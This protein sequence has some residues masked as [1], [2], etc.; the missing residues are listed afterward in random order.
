MDGLHRKQGNRIFLVL[1]MYSQIIVR[2]YVSDQMQVSQTLLYPPHLRMVVRIL[3]ESSHL[4]YNILRIMPSF[5]LISSGM[6]RLLKP[7]KL[8]NRQ[9]V[10]TKFQPY[11]SMNLLLEIIQSLFVLS[12]NTDMRGARVHQS[13]LRSEPVVRR[14]RS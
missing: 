12:I 1:I 11:N 7:L 13:H 3:S 5:G 2:R 8:M 9:L 4:R 14:S 10:P 6:I